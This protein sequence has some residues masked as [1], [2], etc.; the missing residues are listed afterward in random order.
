MESNEKGM[1]GLK[2]AQFE[3]LSNLKNLELSNNNFSTVHQGA[4]QGTH[5]FHSIPGGIPVYVCGD[6]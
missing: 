2:T 5:L 1:Q 4:F 6:A 3:H